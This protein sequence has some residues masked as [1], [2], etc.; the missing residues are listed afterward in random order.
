MERVEQL[1]VTCGEV[2][3]LRLLARPCPAREPRSSQPAVSVNSTGLRVITAESVVLHVTATDASGNETSVSVD[4]TVVASPL[5]DEVLAD[6]TCCPAIARPP[7]RHCQ[8]P[9]CGS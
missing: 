8:I 3:A 7:D 6:R 2:V 9:V 5:C 1:A 4:P